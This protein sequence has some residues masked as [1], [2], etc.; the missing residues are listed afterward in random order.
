MRTASATRV[1]AYDVTF[2]V[3]HTRFNG[4]AHGPDQ[5][6]CAGCDAANRG[7]AFADS[8]IVQPAPFLTCTRCRR[9]G[10]RPTLAPNLLL[11]LIWAS[12]ANTVAATFWAL[13]FLILPENAPH[14]Q[15]VL[16]ELRAV[17][18]ASTGGTSGK[19]N[20]TAAG[21]KGRDRTPNKRSAL[22][23]ARHQVPSPPSSPKVQ[24]ALVLWCQTVWN[25]GVIVL[26]SRRSA[27]GWLFRA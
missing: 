9:S 27:P 24:S 10:L 25:T 22:S 21:A 11:A 3:L 17:A 12:Q 15:R 1:H 14:R 20:G 4:R 5:V 2:H 7:A 16:R 19:G 23:P 18:A 6:D 13:A 26:W 8:N